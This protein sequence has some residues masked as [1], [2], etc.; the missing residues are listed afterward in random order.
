[1]Q[2]GSAARGSVLDEQRL[3]AGLSMLF[4]AGHRPTLDDLESLL[5][6]PGTGG[7]GAQI[8]FRPDE[9]QGWVE[10]LASGLTF[11]LTGLA[12]AEA[13]P[14]PRITHR[15]GVS[16]L[17]TADAL[18]ALALM[19]GPHVTAGVAMLPVVR[20]MVGLAANLSLQLSVEAICWHPAEACMEPQYFA[21]IAL[22]WLA[23]G[24]FP[25]LGLTAVCPTH[26]GHI[27]TQGLAFF[28][29]QEVQVEAK[30]GE[31]PAETIKLAVRIIDFMVR[32]G[33]LTAPRK[34]EGPAGEMLLA[35]PS[36]GGKL[37]WV[38]RES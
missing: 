13:A 23:G 6:S 17:P 5:T 32:H 29:G 33:P 19:P 38:W 12:P 4:S 24:P 35:E 30:A 26:D 18:E 22:N 21:R 28:V 34:I 37:V 11:D 3:S 36:Q 14:F 25:A 31:P 7:P 10:L 2:T 27:V 20:T 8:S 9:P 1:M 15:F 16:G